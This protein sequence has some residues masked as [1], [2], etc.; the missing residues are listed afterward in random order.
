MY[1]SE[2]HPEESPFVEGY[3]TKDLG[4]THRYTVT[5][6][7]RE[8]ARRAKWLKEDPE[9]DLEIPMII[10][11]VNSP[12]QSD[13][14]IR[15]AYMGGGFYS[16]YIIDCD[17]KILQRNPWAWYGESGEWWDLPLVPIGE[18]HTFLDA[19]LENPPSCYRAPESGSGNGVRATEE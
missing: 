1:S 6:D 5:E 11:Y 18:L 9:P 16:G 14:A 2:A 17:G 13:N 12:P 4:W 3:E 19:Y 8:R 10:D 7:M 15:R